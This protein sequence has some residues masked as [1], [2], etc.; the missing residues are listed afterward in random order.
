M[1]LALRIRSLWPRTKNNYICTPPPINSENDSESSGEDSRITLFTVLPEIRDFSIK[2]KDFSSL[3]TP[4]ND[5]SFIM[6]ESCGIAHISPL[7]SQL[8]LWLKK[9]LEKKARETEGFLQTHWPNF[10]PDFLQFFSLIVHTVLG[11][12]LLRH[13]KLGESLFST[14]S[15]MPRLWVPPKPCLDS[16]R[17]QSTGFSQI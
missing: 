12:G 13:Q 3:T 15:E 9:R 1:T 14:I 17:Q 4:L 11:G 5:L 8:F 6:R 16:V 10:W 7:V 2:I